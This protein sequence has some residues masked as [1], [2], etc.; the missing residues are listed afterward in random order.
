M[1]KFG[2]GDQL[3]LAAFV[4]AVY[5]IQLAKAGAAGSFL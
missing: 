5:G 1:K 2:A 3:Q 4:R